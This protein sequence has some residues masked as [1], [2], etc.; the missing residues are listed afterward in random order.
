MHSL[1]KIRA[2]GYLIMLAFAGALSVPRVLAVDRSL[3]FDILGN[4]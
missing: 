2:A 4:P 1:T 3:C